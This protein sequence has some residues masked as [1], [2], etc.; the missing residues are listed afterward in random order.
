MKHKKRKIIH[1]EKI[2]IFIFLLLILSCILF[3]IAGNLNY[4]FDNLFSKYIIIVKD[5]AIPK[6]SVMIAPIVEE[7][8]KFV[9]YV[10]LLFFNLKIISKL[11]Y[12]SK[13]KFLNDYLSVAFL[14][15]AGG[16]GLFEG[17]IHNAG[18]NRLCFIAFISLNMLVHITYSI[19][20]FL[21]GRKYHNWFIC[22]LP[23]GI[24]LHAFHNFL[25][26]LVWDNK[27]V[28]VLMVTVFLLPILL[29]ERKNWYKIFEKFYNVKVEDFKKA[30]RIFYLIF[31]V[32]FVYIFLCCLFAF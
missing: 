9:G 10:V 28:T 29:L 1:Y 23:I 16:F 26:D 3:I 21:L 22:F 31:V 24:L 20:P 7:T 8:I 30:N 5:I 19:Y 25:I 12:A 13:R 2:L 18:F 32:V 27:W 4:H 15:S 11:G 17:A 14:I 6:T